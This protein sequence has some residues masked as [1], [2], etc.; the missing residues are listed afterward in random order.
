M[1]L[2]AHHALL[3]IINTALATEHESVGRAQQ[4]LQSATQSLGDV[5]RELGARA[6]VEHAGPRDHI[7]PR[8]HW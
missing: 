3:P 1:P 2:H 6:R 5:R 8:D 7:A 4:K